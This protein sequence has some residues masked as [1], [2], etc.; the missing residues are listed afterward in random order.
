[1][2][3]VISLMRVW[4]LSVMPVFSHHD[5]I[6]PTTNMIASKVFWLAI[7]NPLKIG[8]ITYVLKNDIFTCRRKF[9]SEPL[10]SITSKYWRTLQQNRHLGKR[11]GFHYLVNNTDY[12]SSLVCY[13]EKNSIIMNKERFWEWY[14]EW[15]MRIVQFQYHSKIIHIFVIGTR[16]GIPM[17]QNRL[18]ITKN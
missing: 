9:S 13:K 8:M 5:L 17:F 6:S 2:L 12:L 16:K 7:W 1:M 11:F 18:W 4:V 14:E 10:V 15:G 3:M